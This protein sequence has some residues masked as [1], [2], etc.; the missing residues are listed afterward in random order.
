MP[1]SSSPALPELVLYTSATCTLCDDAREAIGQVLAERRATGR[2]VPAVHEVDIASDAALE[3]EYRVR[4]PVV[5]L[6]DERLETV[7]GVRRLA[8]LMERVLDG[9]PAS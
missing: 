8:R 1:A 9:V 7:I 6:G 3:E 2:V 5:T 4:L